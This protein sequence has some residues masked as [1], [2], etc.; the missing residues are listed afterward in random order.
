MHTR[1]LAKL[2]LRAV[3]EFGLIEALRRR[4][5]AS[6]RWRV[7]IGDDAAVLR[8]RA[9][10]ELVLTCDAL[11]EDVHFRWRST[12][13]P[14]LAR[15]ALMVNLSD[16]SAMGAA[17]LGFLLALGLPARTRSERLDGF[18][19]A[20]LRAAAD[21][22]CPLVGG[23]TVCAPVWTIAVTAVGELPR[24]RALRRGGARPGQ[25]ILVTGELG[26]AALGLALL[27]RGRGGGR[28]AR[29]FVRRQLAPAPPWRAGVILRRA[30]LATAAIDVSDGLAQDLGHVLRASGVGADLELERLPLA[31]GFA[32][33]CARHG[34]D[35]LQLALAGGEDYELLFCAPARGPSAARLAAR[36]GCRVTEIGRVRKGR[37][38]ALFRG[39][40]R[41]SAPPEG[42][43]HFKT[44]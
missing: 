10:R 20:L 13:A 15:K 25:R 30:G 12:S 32:R 33:Q 14:A 18:V 28:A 17:P 27:E 2:D 21:A 23:D 9:G 34:L 1:G 42:F 11:I 8:P 37:G 24:G 5:R 40:V 16:L 26:A 43:E 19:T 29:P 22:D 44:P 35:P 7:G 41:T 38:L 4:A 3:G 6:P 39:G 36:L 31:R